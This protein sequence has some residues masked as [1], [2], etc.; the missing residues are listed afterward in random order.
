MLM[1]TPHRG[2]RWPIPG[3]PFARL[4]PP[5]VAI[6][7]ASCFRPAEEKVSAVRGPAQRRLLEINDSVECTACV[8]VSSIAVVVIGFSPLAL[9]FDGGVPWAWRVVEYLLHTRLRAT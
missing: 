8:S 7:R 9:N 2:R 1:R 3:S 4:L 5:R 6:C